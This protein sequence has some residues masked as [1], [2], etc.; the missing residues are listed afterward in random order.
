MATTFQDIQIKAATDEQFRAALKRDPRGT[1]AAEGIDVPADSEVLI[2]E[3]TDKQ[4]PLVL[5]PVF[6]GELTEEVL[7]DVV[8]GTHMTVMTT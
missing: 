6:E 1:L 4:I 8:G 5:P 7:S 2:I 3:G